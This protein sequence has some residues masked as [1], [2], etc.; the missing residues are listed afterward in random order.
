MYFDRKI[1]GIW[2]WYP[3]CTSDTWDFTLLH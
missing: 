1:T 2:Q 3:R